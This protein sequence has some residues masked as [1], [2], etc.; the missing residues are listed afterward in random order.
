MVDPDVLS[1]IPYPT[2]VRNIGSTSI[3]T[4]KIQALAM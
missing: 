4:L 3:L 1:A 2:L